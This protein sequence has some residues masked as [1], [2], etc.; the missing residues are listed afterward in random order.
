M[1]PNLNSEF[2]GVNETS[3]ARDLASAFAEAGSLLVEVKP[4]PSPSIG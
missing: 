3:L 2:N 1:T 4:G